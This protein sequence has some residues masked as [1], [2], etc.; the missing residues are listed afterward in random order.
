VLLLLAAA[1]FAP[2]AG[3]ATVVL[4]RSHALAPFDTA[5][6]AFHATCPDSIVDVALDG[7][8]ED[9]VAGVLAAAHPAVIAA[10]GRRA[11][12][13][14][15]ARFPTTPLV[16]ALVRAPEAAGLTGPHVTGIVT[17][18]PPAVELDALTAL[19]P[20][21]HR[22]GVVFGRDAGEPRMRAARAAAAA[23]GIELIEAPIARPAEL[24]E[25]A[26]DLAARADAIWL[27]PDSVTMAPEVF[28]Y[29]L[30]L[31]ISTRRPLLVFSESL[32]RAGALTAVTPDYRWVG[33][34]AAQLAHR[35][36]AGERPSRLPVVPLKHTRVVFNP[37]VAQA[38]ALPPPP[39]LVNL[40]VVP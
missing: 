26:H 23:A 29:L 18:V 27:A 14:A 39:P 10:F 31:S 12:A 21:V 30:D 37:A 24:S 9:S 32:V 34:E 28:R 38:L 33:A 19:A 35:I 8:A 5:A 36:R 40:A 11:A 17:D 22:V 1:G 20:G 2:R 16:Y 13:F 7:A 6:A 3:A 4:L 15:H 25:S